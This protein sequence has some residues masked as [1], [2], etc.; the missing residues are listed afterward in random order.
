LWWYGFTVSNGV[1]LSPPPQR[2]FDDEDR[3]AENDED[4]DAS[5]QQAQRRVVH[6]HTGTAVHRICAN[7][8]AEVTPQ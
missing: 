3:S 6:T 1:S 8:R 5:C 7:T 2:S 4:D